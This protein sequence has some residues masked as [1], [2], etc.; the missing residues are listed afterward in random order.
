MNL[1]ETKIFAICSLRIQNKIGNYIIKS[2][3][4]N[5]N[6]IFFFHLTRRITFMFYLGVNIEINL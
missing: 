6:L 4:L 3:F 2:Y 5:F 1:V